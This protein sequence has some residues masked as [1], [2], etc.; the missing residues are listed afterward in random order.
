[1]KSS[2]LTEVKAL[3]QLTRPLNLFFVILAQVLCSFFILDSPISTALIILFSGTFLITAAGYIINDYFDIKADAINKPK[4][5]YIGRDISRRKALLSVFILNVSA[6]GLSLF[7]P[8]AITYA[9][10]IVIFLLW[11][12]SYLFKRSF[13]IGN[14]LVASM[15]GFSIWILGYFESNLS[16]LLLAFVFFAFITNLIREII[17]DCEDVKGDILLKSK[18]LPIVLGIQGTRFIILSLNIIFLS[19]V[20]YC[21][22]NY[23]L[24][25][26]YVPSSIITVM[27]IL[28]TISIFKNKVPSGFKKASMG[29]KVIMLIGCLS[30]LLL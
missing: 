10:L 9:F 13:L 20:W 1:M 14:L 29:L 17:K 8:R 22:V 19:A 30:I 12:Y 24:N 27:T 25:T 16:V 6:L 4:Q 11:L 26:L 18:T 7:L 15:A 23:G 28:I 21:T 5:V 2:R 3:L